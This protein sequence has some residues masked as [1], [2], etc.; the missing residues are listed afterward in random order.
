M[1]DLYEDVKNSEA[2]TT[3]ISFSHFTKCRPAQVRLMRQSQ[4]RQCLCEYCTNIEL[5]TL[6]VN[7]IAVHRDCNVLSTHRDSSGQ[8]NSDRKQTH[9]S[10][11]L[12]SSNWIVTSYQPH[13]VTSG[14]V[15]SYQPHTVTSG[16]V[17]SYQP[18]TVTSGIVTSCQR[19]WSPQ[20]T[21]IQVI[22]K[23]TFQNSSHWSKHEKVQT[24]AY[25]F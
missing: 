14:I 25:L 19:T 18:H 23:C 1:R 7:G 6:A 9:M 3:P 15:T 8:S 22:S 10:K 21:Q 20:D 4:L 5:K 13:T 11:L 24:N 12:S 2:T 17:T 16:I